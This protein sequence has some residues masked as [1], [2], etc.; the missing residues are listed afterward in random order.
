MK[1]CMKCGRYYDGGDGDY[2]DCPYCGEW[3][4]NSWVQDQSGSMR[5]YRFSSSESDTGKSGETVLDRIF[6]W[7][8]D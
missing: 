1:R 8:S 2:I 3:G 7:L 4:G 5:A 6:D